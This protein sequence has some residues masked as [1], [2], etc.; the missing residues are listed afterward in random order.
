[1]FDSMIDE[2]LF[3]SVVVVFYGYNELLNCYR[4]GGDGEYS[5]P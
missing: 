2:F 4:I 3:C 1:M 5:L